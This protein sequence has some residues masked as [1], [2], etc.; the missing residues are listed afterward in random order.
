MFSRRAGQGESF[1]IDVPVS[2][3]TMFA[4]GFIVLKVKGE[5]GDNFVVFDSRKRTEVQMMGPRGQ[6]GEWLSCV[7]V[8][9]KLSRELEEARN[10]P[11]GPG[12]VFHLTRKEIKWS[13]VMGLFV[14]EVSFG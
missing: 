3:N 10:K 5:E 1:A 7:D 2:I 6:S 14:E 12:N 4:A 8:G 9:E 13:K 11:T